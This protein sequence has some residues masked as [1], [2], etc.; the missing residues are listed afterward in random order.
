MHCSLG[1][2]LAGP[3]LQVHV[4]THEARRFYQLEDRFASRAS[5]AAAPASLAVP[6][7]AGALAGAG[8]GAAAAAAHPGRRREAEAKLAQL[9]RR[10]RGARRAVAVTHF[11]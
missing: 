10:L 6:S 1:G 8:G 2:A 4:L 9:Q 3:R 7:L 5:A 11:G